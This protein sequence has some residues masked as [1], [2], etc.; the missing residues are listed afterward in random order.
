LI[1]IG[2]VSDQEFQRFNVA[3][4]RGLV[5]RRVVETLAIGHGGRMVLSAEV[6]I[7]IGAALQQKLNE[8]EIRQLVGVI[9]TQ[10]RTIEGKL[11]SSGFPHFNRGEQ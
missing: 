1:Q 9:G 10:T 7:G 8:S 6:L 2:A 11:I 4:D 3:H 5:K